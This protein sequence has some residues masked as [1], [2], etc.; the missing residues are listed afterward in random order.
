MA[1]VQRQCVEQQQQILAQQLVIILG[2]YGV[3][4]RKGNRVVLPSNSR[5]TKVSVFLLV[6]IWH[7]SLSKV[8]TPRLPVF[9]PDYLLQRSLLLLP[10]MSFLPQFEPA[11]LPFRPSSSASRYKPRAPVPFQRIFCTLLFNL[12]LCSILIGFDYS[13]KTLAAVI[14]EFLS[15]QL[16]GIVPQVFEHL[17][18]K[19]SASSRSLSVAKYTPRLLSSVPPKPRLAVCIFL[20]M[21]WANTPQLISLLG[22]CLATWF[23]VF[24]P[25]IR[26]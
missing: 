9:E 5:P 13:G 1:A 18:A 22:R 16:E 21:V 8:L 19:R 15:A 4:Q 7:L 26:L 10:R 11:L 23:M 20:L 14:E 6:L 3:P 2:R 25:R 24:H 12:S 17:S